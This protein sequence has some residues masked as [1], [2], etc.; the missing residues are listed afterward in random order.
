MLSK[1]KLGMRVMAALAAVVAILIGVAVYG[2]RQLQ[3]V[4]DSDTV[5]YEANTKALQIA[6]DLVGETNR[7]YT[8]LLQS[9]LADPAVRKSWADR[10]SER[11]RGAETALPRLEERIAQNEFKTSDGRAISL[12]IGLD[13]SKTEALTKSR[14]EMR[15]VSKAG[16]ALLAAMKSSIEKVREGKVDVV[17]E[18]AVSGELSRLRTEFNASLQE[19]SALLAK[20]GQ[21]RSEVNA[22]NA[23]KSIRQL[24]YASVAGVLLAML[25]G[26]LLYRNVRGIIKGLL[27]ETD[28]LAGAAVEGKLSTRA[29]VE[30]VNFEFRG[31]AEGLNKTLD[32]VIGPLNVAAKYVD[33]ISKGNIPPK[34][35][36]TYHGDFN[37]LKDNL[38]RCVDTLNSLIAEMNRMS[39][40][41]D[42]GDIDVV[43]PVEK[44]EG[45]YQTMAKGVNTMVNGHIAVKKKAMACIAEFGRGNIDAALEKFPGKKVFI[46]ETIEQLRDSLK[47]LIAE[48][49]NMSQQHDLGDIDV[50]IPAD[51]FHGAFQ[52]MAKGINGMV[53]G[54]I[55]VKKKAMACIAEFGRGNIDAPLE[56][57]P[58]KKAFIN[59]TI[60]QLRDNLK[61]LIAEMNNMSHQHDLGDIDIMIPAER[62]HGA[63]QTMAKGINGMV[64]GHIAVKK[65]A[66]A[67]I[68][69]FGRGNFDAPLEKFPGKKAFIN[70]TIEQVRA[71]LKALITDANMLAKAAV[72]G[73]LTTRADGSKHQGDF[74]KI[75][76]GVNQT[77]DAVLAPID[78]A[79]QV[80]ERL[81]QRDLRVRVKGNY[82]GDH[83]KI[84]ESIN[85]TAEALHEA[86]LQVAMAVDQVSSA[87]GQ[88][89]SSS[90]SVADGASQQASALEETASSLESM[91]AMTK[92]SA[93]NAQQ[94][95]GL[96]QTAKGAAT[97]GAG[98]MEQMGQAMTKIRAS[99][100]GTSQIIKDINEIAFQTNLLALNAAVEAAR[101]GEA[102]RGFAVVAEEVRSLALRSK[103]AAM[104]TEELIKESVRQAEE[105]EVTSKGVSTKLNEIVTGV[106]KV[107]DIVA[108]ISASAKEQ[109]AGIDQVNR[110]VTDMNK[111]TQQNAANSEE[112]SSAA[113]ELSSQSE[114]LAAMIGGFQLARQTTT[115]AAAKAHKATERK[116]AGHG[117]PG[118]RSTGG[119][120]GKSAM[121]KP[122]EIIPLEEEA[123][124]FK[125]F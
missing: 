101:A 46:N 54:H 97:E 5:L 43:I 78:E 120:N 9:A 71:H 11:V 2:T 104:K 61:T 20:R 105:G 106:S 66:M 122:E 81:S 89:A 70:E 25:L 64:S 79:A 38:N 35:T 109:S 117:A 111:V 110:A 67:C 86:L 12:M 94:A 82:Q 87:S 42:A 33:D 39:R 21:V 32:A 26:F 90:Q 24:T 108:E 113:E 15:T 56:K 62:F 76:E 40:E 88:I 55:A 75:L 3:M 27:D 37:T 10:A 95:N 13:S 22:E 8:N 19:L 31:V 123:A 115:H 28:R 73:K 50:M 41:H 49:N 112:S 93:D 102:G 84:K 44:F 68:G 34:I 98:A 63:F 125:D 65:K 6:G 14:E 107:T 30:A 83:A 99:A 47:T 36:D 92:R 7:G 103:E 52:T 96:A 72:E 118:Q 119:N 53:S 16:G 51:R 48:M 23:N 29:D 80:L 4:D 121:H 1:M 17:G 57:F 60:E 58:G 74:R 91:S 114:E 69:E 100:E 59:D 124:A 77:L 116:A 45:A 18:S 85:A